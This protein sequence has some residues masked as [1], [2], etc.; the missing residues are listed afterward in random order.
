MEFLK[1]FA[2]PEAK[3]KS[4]KPCTPWRHCTAQV[5]T[6]QYK[7]PGPDRYFGSPAGAELA[8]PAKDMRQEMKNGRVSK[9]TRPEG[10][11][12]RFAA[13]DI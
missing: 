13:A 2:A 12:V 7:C 4:P 10:M 5:R 8:R 11:N 3:A 1:V 9:D 6:R